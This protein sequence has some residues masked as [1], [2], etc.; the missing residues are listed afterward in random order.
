MYLCVRY[1][2]L[3][4]IH[5]YTCTSMY[6]LCTL[7]EN[8]VYIIPNVH[9]VYMYMSSVIMIFKDDV[10]DIDPPAFILHDMIL[11]ILR[12]FILTKVSFFL[13]VACQR[14]EK[15]WSCFTESFVKLHC[16]T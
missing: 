12:E 3:F 8:Y 6:E 7:H 16:I 5:A 14:K 2:C 4:H 9:A 1:S 13:I 10:N 11:L 15:T